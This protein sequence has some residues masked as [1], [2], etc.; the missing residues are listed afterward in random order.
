M[1]KILLMMFSLLAGNLSTQDATL[2]AQSFEITEIPELNKDLTMTND[3]LNSNVEYYTK[4][5]AVKGFTRYDE[6]L[7]GGLVRSGSIMNTNIWLEAHTTYV[8][9]GFGA[10][11]LIDLDMA[12]MKG[13][14]EVASDYKENKNA[15]I[16]YTPTMSGPYQISALIAKC[17]TDLCDFRIVV[18]KKKP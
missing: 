5:G 13:S 14:N 18:L 1:K 4:W 12:I 7:I 11:N 17:Q 15:V 2:F 3:Y 10:Y 16:R 8:L 6:N 9:A